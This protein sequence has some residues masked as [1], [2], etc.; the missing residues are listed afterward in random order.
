MDAKSI[1]AA[2]IYLGAVVAAVASFGGV[3]MLF[4]RLPI[5]REARYAETKA[6]E[7]VFNQHSLL[8]KMHS[9][10]ESERELGETASNNWAKRKKDALAQISKIRTQAER[11][12]DQALWLTVERLEEDVRVNDE[13]YDSYL[14]IERVNDMI[15]EMKLELA[16]YETLVREAREAS[17]TYQWYAKRT[18]REWI[19]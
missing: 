10:I 4:A 14:W 1:V 17:T 2:A 15:A 9:K 12:G 5:A 8:E 16:L 18:I 11:A 6:W 3:L 7:A 13:R 19:A